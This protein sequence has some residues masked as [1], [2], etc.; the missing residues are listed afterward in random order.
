VCCGPG[1]WDYVDWERYDRNAYIPTC[2]A[3]TEF[4]GGA[5]L[6]GLNLYAHDS[7]PFSGLT[8]AVG[9]LGPL[10]PGLATLDLDYTS[11]TGGIGGLSGASG[12]TYL[13]LYKT[14]VSGSVAA[15]AGCTSG[16]LGLILGG[17]MVTGWPLATAGG[18]IF[19]DEDD[20]RC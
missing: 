7:R 18:C 12:L 16:S 8:G 5:L 2:P 14:G 19:T 13:N 9:V 11:V 1:G 4:G 3:V 17:T 20:Y 6:T 15:L 10:G